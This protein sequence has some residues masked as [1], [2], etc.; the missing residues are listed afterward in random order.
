MDQFHR[1][2]EITGYPM[3][4]KVSVT[5]SYQKSKCLQLTA[6]KVSVYIL[7]PKI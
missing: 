5:S 1:V 7:L 4:Q 3:V 6:R 2:K